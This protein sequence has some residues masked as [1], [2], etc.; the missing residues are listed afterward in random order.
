MLEAELPPNITGEDARMPCLSVLLIMSSESGPG[1][2]ITMTMAVK[3]S[4]QVSMGICFVTRLR[5]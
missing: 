3:K 4:S 5:G 1:I 2:A